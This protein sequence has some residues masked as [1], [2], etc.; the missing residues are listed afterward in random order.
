MLRGGDI[1]APQPR[2][3]SLRRSAAARLCAAPRRR[4]RCSPACCRARRRAA[5]RGP[6]ARADAAPARAHRPRA[7]RPQFPLDAGAAVRGLGRLVGSRA[8]ALAGARAPAGHRRR[9]IRLR[10]RAAPP[11][12][13][14]AVL[15]LGSP[16]RSWRAASWAR[17]GSSRRR[18]CC[19][20][21][22]RLGA[23]ARYAITAGRRARRSRC[24]SAPHGPSRSRCAIPRTSRVVGRAVSWTDWFGPLSREG[25]GGSGRPRSRTCSGSRG[26]RCRS[27]CGRCGC[28]A[29]AST[30]VSRR[31]PSSF[32]ERSRLVMLVSIAVMAEPR[33]D[34]PDAA[35]AAAC[36]SRRARDRHAEARLL[37]RAR[38][39]RH[40]DV[41]PRSRRS[42]GGF[43]STPT[44]SGMS[45]PVA[46]A[47][48]RHRSRLPAAVR[49]A[50]DRRL[51]A[52]HAAVARARAPGAALESA[53]GAELGGGHDAAVGAVLDDLAALS[54]FAPQLPRR[55][56]GAG[57]R[58][59]RARLRREPQ[60]RRAA[61]RAVPVFRRPRDD[62]RGNDAAARLRRRCSSSTGGST[63][64]PPRRM[65]GRSVWEGQRRGDDTERFVALHARSRDEVHRR[66]DDR[67]R[68]RRRRQ[69]R[70]RRSGA[71]STCR[72][73]APT[74]ATAATA[75]ASGR[76]PTATSTR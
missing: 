49:L 22:S 69:R 34:V 48:P 44:R 67:G 54:R 11:V 21:R 16:S 65:A 24:R 4:P 17:C 73:A 8:P 26:P 31:P 29:A 39:V 7:L 41:R 25:V 37:G 14:G 27:R 10:A 76:S 64:P 50:C 20:S 71:R 38:L 33:V 63:A 52:A 3:R 46:S 61:A 47:V 13:G 72:A 66:S 9:A 6:P 45:L 35:A 70:R 53:R 23:R 57:A 12:A 51:G 30:A 2:G 68:R 32:R 1:L 60:P 55:R 28:A 56:A 36:A 18:S 5:R 40:P 75:A 59:C 15:G 42:R 58:T 74:A 62:A 43:G 19:R